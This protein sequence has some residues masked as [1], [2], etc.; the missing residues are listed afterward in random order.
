M[1][2]RK[3]LHLAVTPFRICVTRGEYFQKKKQNQKGEFTY[4]QLVKIVKFLY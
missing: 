4:V 3:W 1:S 2:Q